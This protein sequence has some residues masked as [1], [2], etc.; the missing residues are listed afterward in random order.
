MGTGPRVQHQAPET[1]PRAPTRSL[2]A[3]T[4]TSPSCTGSPYESSRLGQSRSS[5]HSSAICEVFARPESVDRGEP[6]QVRTD[7]SRVLSARQTLTSAD[8][9]SSYRFSVKV[10]VAVTD[11]LPLVV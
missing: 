5:K 9:G 2:A 8:A 3:S 11:R 10:L 7:I 1:A 6:E 4:A